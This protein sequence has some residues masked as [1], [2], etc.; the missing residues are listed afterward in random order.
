MSARMPT[1][2]MALTPKKG[3]REQMMNNTDNGLR[4]C[5]QMERS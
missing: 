4:S 5:P 2:K 3:K 1:K